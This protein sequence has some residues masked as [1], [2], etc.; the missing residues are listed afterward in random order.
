[1]FKII[2]KYFFMLFLALGTFVFSITAFADSPLTATDIYTAYND[3]EI[4]KDAQESQEIDKQI[5]YYL[6][7]E[8]NPIDVKIA[9]INAVYYSRSWGSNNESTADKYT[10]LIY[11]KKLEKLDLDT[12]NED[13]LLCIGYIMV[14]DD[15]FNPEKS[16]AILKK[17]LDKKP[18]S[19]TYNII[20]TLAKTQQIM[21]NGDDWY[22][23]YDYTQK[24][25]NNKKLIKDMRPEAITIITNYQYLYGKYDKTQLHEILTN[26]DIICINKSKCL[27]DGVAFNLDYN[28]LDAK[29]FRYVAETMIPLGFVSD[30][31]GAK[32]SVDNKKDITIS[33]KDKSIKM[34]LGNKKIKVNDKTK[35]IRVTARMKKDTI[36]IPLS[37][38]KEFNKKIYT[39]KNGVTVIT[40]Q[41]IK[42]SLSDSVLKDIID[43]MKDK[44]QY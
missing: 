39:Y 44:K 28:N 25:V 27:I 24:V 32:V 6:A 31:L 10:Q 5:A 19:F 42:P 22:F 30:A 9:V 17:A 13:Q 38:L 29:P 8:K 11:S 12:L 18:D 26:T 4:I 34:T 20:Y 14:L 23:V 16:M 2:N 41:K 7:D 33:L 36:Y 35:N 15:Y 37:I 1:M 21:H 3:V 43:K 40:D